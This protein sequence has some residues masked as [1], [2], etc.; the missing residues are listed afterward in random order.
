M[1]TVHV[2]ITYLEMGHPAMLRPKRVAR[3]DVTVARVDPP[4]PEV[5]ERFYC[6]VG[7][8]Y[9]WF[10]RAEW[11]AAQWHDDLTQP[12]TEL[13]VLRVDG[14]EAGYF[15]LTQ[16]AART[17]EILYLGM[18]PGW[19]TDGL[20]GHLLTSAVERAWEAGADRVIVNT[21]TLD[22]PRALPNYL[23]RGF[24][25]VREHTEWRTLPDG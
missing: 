24:E 14:E 22:H 19:E 23:A 21:C 17:R 16:P 13:W 9:Y 3:T 8:E 25:I 7:N 4:L 18:L 15:H 1:P 10:E 12:G 11:S 5:A 20:G 2:T 6:G